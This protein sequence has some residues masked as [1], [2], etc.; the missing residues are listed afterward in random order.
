MPESSANRIA[1]IGAAG[2]LGRVLL[3]QLRE[4]GI[5]VT[6]VARGPRELVQDGT[7]HRVDSP[8]EAALA[9]GY[10]VVVNL[11]FPGG[12]KSYEDPRRNGELASL[13]EALL[14]EGG[15]LIHASS[16]AVFG[17]RLDHPIV[18]TEVR[19]R[20]D[21]PYVESKITAEHLFAQ[22]QARREGQLDIVRFGNIWGSASASYALPI[23]Q[24]LVAGRPVGVQNHPQYSNVTDVHNAA[25]YLMYLISC[26][27]SLPGITYRHLAEFS[28]VRWPDWIRP[29]ADALGV[30]PVEVPASV[31]ALPHGFAELSEV[32]APLNP[33]AVYKKLSDERI[34]G[35]VIRATVRAIPSRLRGR[36]RAPTAVHA[37]PV[38]YQ[39]ADRTFLGILAAEQ[40][41]RSA[42]LGSWSPPYDQA[43]ST[44]RVLEWLALE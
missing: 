25:S 29:V 16:V 15:H 39:R 8:D 19:R 3:R 42:D 20:R 9:G 21:E 4:S 17:F 43:T 32:T 37:G 28:D 30:D 14:R 38:S 33:R 44:A 27:E 6:A 34:A 40:Q 1:V 35:S 36:L 26:S 12:G 24:R 5:A 18:T 31:L 2:F 22:I 10:E 11:A 7:F 23:V 13:A 41:F